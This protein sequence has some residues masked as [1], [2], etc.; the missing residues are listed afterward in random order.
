MTAITDIAAT[1]V[2]AE[3]Q[4]VEPEK[5][6]VEEERQEETQIDD[7]IVDEAWSKANKAKTAAEK[8]VQNLKSLRRKGKA[9]STKITAARQKVQSRMMKATKLEIAAILAEDD[10]QEAMTG[11]TRIEEAMAEE[12]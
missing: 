10:F 8:A 2:N 6:K 1:K 12:P 4:N 7:E 9:G 11:K 5:L 3:T